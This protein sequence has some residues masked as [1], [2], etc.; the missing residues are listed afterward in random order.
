MNTGKMMHTSNTWKNH[1]VIDGIR[2]MYVIAMIIW[3]RE[4]VRI[5]NRNHGN[6]WYI[7]LP[8][9]RKVNQSVLWRRNS[10]M[11]MWVSLWSRRV[12][13]W[14]TFKGAV[15]VKKAIC[16]ILSAVITGI[17]FEYLYLPLIFGGIAGMLCTT[18]WVCSE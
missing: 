9:V 11:R 10:E 5:Y 1:Y 13:G 17:G 8:K 18:V 2:I 4:H 3:W 12:W 14:L 6:R 16:F 15:K 7:V